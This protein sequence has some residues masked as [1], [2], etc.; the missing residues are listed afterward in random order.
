MILPPIVFPGY[1]L[2]INNAM[3]FSISTLIIKTFNMMV[4]YVYDNE[5]TSFIVIYFYEYFH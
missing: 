4:N 3:A 2:T 1:C 5:C